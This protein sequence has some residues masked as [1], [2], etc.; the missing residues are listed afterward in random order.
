M[1][2]YSLLYI[3][4]GVILFSFT[5]CERRPLED[6]A[7]TLSALVRFKI[8]WSA[9]GVDI[10]DMHRASIWIFSKDGSAVLEHRL[11]SNL[12]ETTIALPVGT[13]SFLVFNETIDANDWTTI[14]FGHTDNFDTFSAI[15]LPGSNTYGNAQR[16][17]DIRLSPEPL[18]S[19]SISDFEVTTDMVEITRSRMAKETRAT[20]SN[21]TRAQEQAVDD[22]LQ[23]LLEIVPKPLTYK[24][25]VKAYVHYLVSSPQVSGSLKGVFSGVYMASRKPIE[26]SVVHVFPFSQRQYDDAGK[27]VDGTITS[28]LNIFGIRKEV[29]DEYWLEMTFRLNNGQYKEPENFNVTSQM[30]TTEGIV[31]QIDVGNDLGEE[32]EEED[33]PIILPDVPIGD[34]VDVGDWEDHEIPFN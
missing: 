12:T 11:E 1:K 13:Y 25:K 30:N 15:A 2:Y 34:N 24:V 14:T 8:D 5:G 23:S 4:C 10:T 22:A 33:H 16:D 3:V 18:A 32:K 9:S 27:P 7:S 17:A 28:N 31:I 19:W 21:V 29:S 6:R 26:Q 20:A